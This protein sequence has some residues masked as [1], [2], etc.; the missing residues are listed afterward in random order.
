MASPGYEE[1]D[2]TADIALRVWGKDL[3]TFLEQ[4]AEG[5]YDLV[6][7]EFAPDSSIDITF[8]LQQGPSETILV[9][10]LSELLYLLEERAQVFHTFSFDIGTDQ[11]SIRAICSKVLSIDRHIKAVTFHN[12]NIEKTAKGLEA[13]ITFDV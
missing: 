2:H 10:F 11:I 8:D 9:D 6:G 5:M 4:A 12:L 7:I 13:T 1:V 3:Q